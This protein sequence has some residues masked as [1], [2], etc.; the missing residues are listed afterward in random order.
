VSPLARDAAPQDAPDD[1]RQLAAQFEFLQR[2]LQGVDRRL[3]QL[4]QAL[5]EAQQAASAVQALAESQGAQ[6]ALLPLGSG[7]HV[8]AKVDPTAPVLLPIGAG[9]FTEG[10]AKEIVA[11]LGARVEAITKSFQ[12]TS[13][14]A[15]RLAQAAAT[16]NSRLESLSPQ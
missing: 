13:A 10:P 11:A 16:I 1:P 3:A 6:E 4:E 12:E 8:H 2:Q 9:Y 15:E 7:V 14:D 5:V